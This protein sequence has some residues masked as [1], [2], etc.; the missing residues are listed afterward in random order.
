MKKYVTDTHPVLWFLSKDKR[1]SRRA[2]TIFK[3]ARDGW[4]LITVPSIVLVEAILLFQR[5]RIR[6][7]TV[8]LVG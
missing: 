8:R 6:E 7:E 1:L 2:R 5:R 3:R 4:D